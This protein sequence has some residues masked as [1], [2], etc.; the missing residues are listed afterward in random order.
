MR[1][2]YTE[3]NP[4]NATLFQRPPQVKSSKAHTH[5][6]FH[7]IPRLRFDSEKK[8]TSYAGIVVFQALFIAVQLRSQLKRC[9]QHLKVQNIYGH[10]SVVLLLVVH[11]ILGFRRL[12]GLDYY[13]HDPMVARVVGLRALPDVATVSRTLATADE[14]SVDRY[15]EVVRNGVLDRLCWERMPRVTLDFDGSVLSTT[16][17]REGTAV[18]YNKK[19]KGARSYYPLFCT[20]AQTVQFFDVLH[21]AGN[22]HD[23]NGAAEF[24]ER[25]FGYLSD[26]LPHAILEGRF[27]SAFFSQQVVEV[28][29]KRGVLFTCTVPFERLVELKKVVEERRRWNTINE[30]WSYFEFEWKPKKWENKYRLLCLRQRR[31]EQHKGPLQLDLFEPKDW[32]YDYKVVMT[33]KSESAKNS[34]LF[35]N[36][37]GSQEKLLGEAKQHAALD[38]IPS[39]RKVGNQIFLLSA[40]L[41]HNLG[42]EIQMRAREQ[43]R[44]TG[45]KRPALWD[46]ANL[47]TI[48]QHLVHT[49]GY[50]TN[51]QGELTLT[52]N[53]SDAARADMTEYLEAFDAA[54]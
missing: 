27:D 33:N 35:H 14:K 28:L 2:G 54:A 4:T 20:T 38:I 30:Q 21:R 45:Y 48:R 32:T 19:K 39:R 16:G 41:A 15:R 43:Q 46:F 25:C 51:P 36:G 13:R 6:K 50:L 44:G 49:A 5:A 1:K 17:H 11:L 31:T 52:M 40:M 10:A 22:V 23:S 37:R 47:G 18:G 42:R 29:E 34:L 53:V 9:F 7:K 12:R 26:R 8:L 24:I 3:C